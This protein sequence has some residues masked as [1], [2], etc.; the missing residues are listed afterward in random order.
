MAM[1]KLNGKNIIGLSEQPSAM[2]PASSSFDELSHDIRFLPIVAYSQRSLCFAR[3]SC[4]SQ[5][6][7][8]RQAFPKCH[9]LIGCAGAASRCEKGFSSLFL[10][11]LESG[12]TNSVLLQAV[13]ACVCGRT[14]RPAWAL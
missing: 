3:T 4:Q 9:S 5:L 8:V 12:A 6:S 13:A 2:P 7:N 1:R 10:L 14:T 11:V